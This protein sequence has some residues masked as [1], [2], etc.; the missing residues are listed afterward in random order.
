MAL[1]LGVA[2]AANSCTHFGLGSGQDFVVATPIPNGESAMLEERQTIGNPFWGRIGAGLLLA[3][4]GL[5]LL[6]LTVEHV[7]DQL[8][9][10]DPG[11]GQVARGLRDFGEKHDNRLPPSAVYGPDGKPL[12]SWRVLVLPSLGQGDL[13]KEFHLD[14]PWDSPHNVALLPRMPAVY[15]PPL[16]KRSRVPP[17]HTVCHVFVGKDTAFEGTRGVRI[18]ANHPS[19]AAILLFVEAGEPV[20]WT[21]PEEI[22]GDSYGPLP[23]LHGVFKDEFRAACLD[24]HVDFMKEPTRFN[25]TLSER[26]CVRFCRLPD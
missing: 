11:L 5:V 26:M 9:R 22:D 15:A 19:A 3:V 20:P 17:Y 12:L 8:A 18:P 24:G 21:K 23:D 7:L 6:E 10:N 4:L 2:Q 14:E 13:Y 25:K 1:R 16:G